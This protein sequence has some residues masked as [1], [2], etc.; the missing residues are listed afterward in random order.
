MNSQQFRFFA[1][2]FAV[3]IDARRLAHWMLIG[4]IALTMV[5]SP[6][7]AHHHEGG[8]GGYGT[9]VDQLSIDEADAD[10]ER[11][12]NEPSILK[13]VV[14]NAH[15]GHSVSALRG[16]AAKVAQ[17]V[18]VMDA[19]LLVSILAFVVLLDPPVADRLTGWHPGRER[20]PIPLFRT[21][22]PD[23]RAPPT[24]HL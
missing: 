23:G 8:P 22:P 3:G 15:V 20:V 4:V 13:A 19:R 11:E 6:F 10:L 14:D 7:H 2:I 5:S 1:R 9:N 12:S 18:S 24:L 17:V 21:V 16:A